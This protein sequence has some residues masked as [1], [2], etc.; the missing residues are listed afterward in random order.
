MNRYENIQRYKTET[1]TTYLGITRYPEI[2]YSEN[3]IYIYVTVGDRLDN[4]AYQYYGDS[5]LY[6]IILAANPNLSYNLMYPVPGAQMRI[7]FPVEDVM[8]RFNTVNNG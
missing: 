6:W 4:I 7:P 5:T 3:D 2:P 1:G 8:N